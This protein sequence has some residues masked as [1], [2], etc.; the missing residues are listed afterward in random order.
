MPVRLAVRSRVRKPR[1]VAALKYCEKKVRHA[2]K[3]EAR[4]VARTVRKKRGWRLYAYFCHVCLGW[5]LTK[6][7]GDR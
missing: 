6:Q 4:A 1:V 2:N 3:A 7:R 5:H